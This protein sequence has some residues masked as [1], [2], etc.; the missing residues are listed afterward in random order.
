LW[1][2]SLDEA[3]KGRSC[4]N[5]IGRKVIC[6]RC[7]KLELVAVELRTLPRC[8]V[9]FHGQ[10]RELPPRVSAGGLMDARPDVVLA[11]SLET[12]RQPSVDSASPR[13]RKAMMTYHSPI[14]AADQFLVNRELSMV[15]IGSERP[16]VPSSRAVLR[17][18]RR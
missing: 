14:M 16:P 18:D 12:N 7:H 15:P 8:I 3:H 5:D 10:K 9:K 4:T 2:P 13:R 17:R 1:V 6:C 11:S